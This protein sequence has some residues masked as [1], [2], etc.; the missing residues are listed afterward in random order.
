M[1]LCGR[2]VWHRITK[3][4]FQMRTPTSKVANFKLFHLMR[5]LYRSKFIA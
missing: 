4:R 5:G 3:D 2:L 1:T